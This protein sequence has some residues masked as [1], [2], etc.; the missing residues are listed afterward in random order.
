[1]SQQ[2]G[3]SASD[4]QWLL[5]RG[6]TRQAAIKPGDGADL[7]CTRDSQSLRALRLS[8]MAIP[9]GL[10]EKLSALLRKSVTTRLTGIQTIDSRDFMRG[11]DNPT[12]LCVVRFGHARERL[13]LELV[14]AI[15]FPIVDRL[16]GGGQEACPAV[17][18]PLTSIEERL[19]S[20]FAETCLAELRRAWPK[21]LTLDSSVERIESHPQRVQAD[22]HDEQFALVV[23]EIAFGDVRGPL[24]LFLP[25]SFCER[26]NVADTDSGDE[27][28]KGES[29]GAPRGVAS[30][31]PPM[32][33]NAVAPVTLHVATTKI[34]ATDLVELQPNDI[35][36]TAHEVGAPL[37]VS[38]DGVPRFHAKPGACQGRKAFEI[39]GTIEPDA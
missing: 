12:C 38:V 7:Q 5:L 24:R 17:R 15:L 23:Y 33:R 11:L 8:Q 35:I 4:V 9:D 39:E 36:T 3:L 1:M 13:L 14:P 2:R 19:T 26:L 31:H 10:A 32:E 22:L 29:D 34:K 30:F 16:L 6:R 28:G 18:R 20:R 25:L 27:T 21:S 37:T